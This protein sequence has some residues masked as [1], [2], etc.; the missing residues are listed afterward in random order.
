MTKSPARLLF[1]LALSLRVGFALVS[2]VKPVFPAHYYTD[3]RLMEE[4]A[5]DMVSSWQRG[6]EYLSARHPS[7]RTHAFL[8]ACCYRAFGF[9]PLLTKILNSF[10]GALVIVVFFK[11]SAPL[12]GAGPAAISA[13]CL[14]LW[15]SH[16]FFTS[17][18]FKDSW[19]LLLAYA[20]LAFVLRI[21]RD[22]PIRPADGLAAV[23]ALVGVGFLRSYLAA[24]TACVLAAGLCAE[25][26]RRLR[27][28]LPWGKVL[29]TA[30][31]VAG[32]PVLYLHL[33]RVIFTDC[34]K[35]PPSD[36][37]DPAVIHAIMPPTYSPSLDR[38]V[39]PY[40]PRNLS[41]TRRVRQLSDR[42]WAK[43]NAGREIGTQL[44]VDLEFNNWWDVLAFLPKGVF[45]VLFMP[46]PGLYAMDGN[47]GRVLAALENSVL[48]ILALAGL[49]GAWRGPKTI[50]RWLLLSLFAVMAA[51]S[52]L[53]EFD[54]G[55]ATRHK[56]LYLPL[57]F[58]FAAS[59][60]PRRPNLK[61]G[62]TKVLEVLECG[63]PGGTGNQVAAIC[64][65]LDPRRFDAVLVYAVRPGE[66]P[67]QYRGQV[68]GAKTA[69]HVPDMV[70]EIS[71]GRDLKAFVR[72][73]SIMRR[74]AP[75]AVHAHSSK[76]GVLARL[77]AW[78]TGAP[79]VFYSPHGYSFLQTDRSP[80]SRLLYRAA[81]WSV[82]W[83]GEIV[84]V[85]PSEARLA[86]SLNW[87]N[88][89]HTVCDPYLGPAEPPPPLPHEGLALGACGRLTAAR[90]PEAF[91]RLAAGLRRARPDARFIW[92]GGGEQEEDIRRLAHERGLQ[93]NL[94]I[95]G[96]L[97]PEQALEKMRELDILV[98]YS[99]WEGLP[100]AVLEA[101]ALGL[102]V[103]A[104]DAPGNQDAVIPDVTGLLARDEASLLRAA[105]RLA[106]DASL[107]RKLG[108]AG[109]ER[110]LLEFT[111]AQALGALE[112]LYAQN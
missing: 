74:E 109:R 23:G 39:A 111:P 63:G 29:A 43:D 88:P 101:M 22:N 50:A 64:N 89:V 44:F 85:S 46:L 76:A 14:S 103:V 66:D 94:E 78:L 69:Y 18:N 57:L 47:L 7:Q 73:C 52:A 72:L 93:G 9:H 33:S 35:P 24:T 102:P 82:S 2:E 91:V 71:L 65:G 4:T 12:F 26:A 90:N 49:L 75:D 42:I 27:R 92:I 86:R 30:A 105:L 107:R 99:R 53:L 48:L 61:G 56:I 11:F 110:I 8:L 106:H 59:L 16:I 51:G 38:Y 80:A 19:I 25:T 95:T 40:S 96:W 3:A 81:E 32:A 104:S 68:P 60:G 21:F 54:L 97:K 37:P 100:N 1:L 77:A 112:K 45:Y 13:L 28:G 58:P 31:L 98:H 41:E 5:R 70:R 15:P 36:V 17:Q 79:R 84:A 67:E 108:Q 34:L 55:S 10:F 62:R 20:A 83:I 6:E 87:G